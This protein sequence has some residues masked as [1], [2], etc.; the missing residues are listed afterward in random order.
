MLRY[1]EQ[2]GLIQSQR[3]DDYAYRVYDETAIN[4]LRQVIVLRKLRVPVKQIVSILNNSD[5]AKIVEVFE[6]N[7]SQIDVEIT[8]LSTVREILARFVE[9]LHGKTNIN[10]KLLDSDM[11]S[12]IGSLSFSNNQI[13]EKKESLLMEEL[14]KANEV[15]NKLTD[16]DVRI[17]HLPPTS[18]VAIHVDGKGREWQATHALEWLMRKSE[19][20]K[21]KPDARCF[22][23]TSH[24]SM[25]RCEEDTRT[26]DMLV[27]IPDDFEIPA[28]EPT[29]SGKC[30][31]ARDIEIEA[32]FVKLKFEGGLYAAHVEWCMDDWALLGDWVKSNDLYECD[33]ATERFPTLKCG[34]SQGLDE[35]LNLKNFMELGRLTQLDL[36]YPIKPKAV[37]L[38]HE[39]PFNA[40]KDG[41]N[42]WNPWNGLSGYE[43]SAATKLVVEIEGEFT[44]DYTFARFEPIAWTE[45]KKGSSHI[46]E[47]S[48]KIIFDLTQ[49]SGG[50]LAFAAWGEDDSAKVKRV[51][52]I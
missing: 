13:Q 11:F 6:Q 12:V 10:L 37:E 5:T 43:L 8:A 15:M 18:A 51:Y 33:W 30:S 40:E 42:E 24:E 25:L 49:S 45:F 14:N 38:P 27:T 41:F 36:H 31:I 3:K 21:I 48:G 7:I 16:Q 50:R 52:L 46:A 19:L 2:V 4:R 22:C 9:E 26:Y 32:T 39:L 34:D 28:F 35:I 29:K 1:Y 47:E 17:V 23:F 44:S 20:L